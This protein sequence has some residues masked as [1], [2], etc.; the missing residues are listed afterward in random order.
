LT[1][2]VAVFAFAVSHCQARGKSLLFFHH[3]TDRHKWFSMDRH[4][5]VSPRI[6]GR[7]RAAPEA[8]DMTVMD[9][10]HRRE[11]LSRELYDNSL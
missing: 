7:W 10:E 6:A 1:T 4:G 11:L 9:G 5:V 2:S 3:V 8:H